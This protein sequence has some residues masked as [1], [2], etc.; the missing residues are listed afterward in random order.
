MLGGVKVTGC[1]ARG[2]GALEPTSRRGVG[3]TP[4]RAPEAPG[5]SRPRA[6]WRRPR[7]ERRALHAPRS[8]R[9]A[10]SPATRPAESRPRGEPWP[11]P[12]A[13]APV[14]RAPDGAALR[15]VPRHPHRSGPHGPSSA[16]VTHPI[17][18][19]GPRSGSREGSPGLNHGPLGGPPGA[20]WGL[21]R[22]RLVGSR[23]A[24]E[25][26]HRGIA[27]PLPPRGLA[28]GA[29]SLGGWMAPVHTG[30]GM[31]IHSYTYD[32]ISG[33]PRDLLRAL[34]NHPRVDRRDARTYAVSPLSE[35]CRPYPALSKGPGA[36][37]P[38][39][40]PPRRPRPAA[41]AGPVP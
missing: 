35:R 25:R 39:P 36:P 2:P 21:H 3:R 10:C 5:W 1:R 17:E 4:A 40:G 13:L 27:G 15:R 6:L 30:C 14:A 34:R 9:K 19:P 22:T 18:D 11:G 7:E 41:L 20:P 16:P 31:E 23:R 33:P 29:G 24:D 8:S 38:A 12:G 32:G 26:R 37:R 28:M